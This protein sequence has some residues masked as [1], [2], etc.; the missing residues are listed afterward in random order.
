MSALNS[1]MDLP[2]NDDGSIDLYFGPTPPPQGDKSWV[3][4]KPGDGFF[5]YLR[6]DG[7]LEPCYDETWRPSD[8]VKVK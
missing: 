6:F 5:M 2:V 1:Y 7:P 3:K 8:V 4:T